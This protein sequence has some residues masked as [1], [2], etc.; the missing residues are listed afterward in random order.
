MVTLRERKPAVPTKPV[1]ES[2]DSSSNESISEPQKNSR[3]TANPKKRV[4]EFFI[5]S[6]K[7]FARE[8]NNLH[9]L[10]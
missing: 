2:S 5:F 7:K 1:V 6:I 10:K 4:K 9:N 8:N 3:P